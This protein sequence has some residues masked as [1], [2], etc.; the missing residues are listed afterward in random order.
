MMS[1]SMEVV[2]FLI[3]CGSTVRGASGSGAA[4]GLALGTGFGGACVLAG[5]GDATTFTEITVLGGTTVSAGGV[6]ETTLTIF[7]PGAFL[8]L[9][10]GAVVDVPHSLQLSLYSGSL[11]PHFRQNGIES[12][13]FFE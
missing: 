10:K 5:L 11:R 12:P 8:I 1:S 3:S 6:G 13:C 2:L 4:T 9:I 7:T